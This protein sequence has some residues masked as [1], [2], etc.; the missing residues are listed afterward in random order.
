MWGGGTR[1]SPITAS[2]MC[3]FH[4][5]FGWPKDAEI[6]DELRYFTKPAS[7]TDFRSAANFN[8][9]G[10]GR[11]GLAV[12]YQALVNSRAFDV[13]HRGITNFP[14][15]LPRSDAESA[16]VVLMV[17][18]HLQCQPARVSR[19]VV[20]VAGTSWSPKVCDLALCHFGR[21]EDASESELRVPFEICLSRRDCM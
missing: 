13:V 21:P 20:V 18:G 2:E 8:L 4:K 3:L 10:C 14:E 12:C 6:V 7:T 16:S 9:F 5:E 17:E 11:S 1:G 19:E 15:N